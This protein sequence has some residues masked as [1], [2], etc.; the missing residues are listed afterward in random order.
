MEFAMNQLP[1]ISWF[2]D[3]DW[4]MRTLGLIFCVAINLC[5]YVTLYYIVL[6]CNI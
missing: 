1:V 4:R 3:M 5:L 2:L 6:Q